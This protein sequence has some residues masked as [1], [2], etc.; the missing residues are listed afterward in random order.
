MK[1]EDLISEVARLCEAIQKIHSSV[2]DAL[3][4]SDGLMQAM[5]RENK[6]NEAKAFTG[7]NLFCEKDK[8]IV[9]L[10]DCLDCRYFDIPGADL[11]CL[12]LYRE[13]EK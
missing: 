13:V 2:H 9:A 10:R 7:R 5:E 11:P 3:R 4:L 1:Q 12:C 6:Q 8:R